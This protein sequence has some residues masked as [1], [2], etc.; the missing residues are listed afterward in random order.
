LH[1]LRAQLTR[2]RASQRLHYSA[3]GRLLFSDFEVY[4]YD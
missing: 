1:S 4:A 3:E 2:P